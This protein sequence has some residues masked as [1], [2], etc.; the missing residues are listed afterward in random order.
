MFGTA[1]AS[2]PG[3]LF[4]LSTTSAAQ[5]GGLFGSTPAS[6]PAA[7]GLF[8]TAPA[9]GQTGGLFGSNS[10]TSK[11]GGG[12]FGS[13]ATTQP[14]T[15]GLFGSAQPQQQSGGL[16]GSTATSQPAPTGLFGASTTTSQPQQAGGLFGAT[17][18]AAPSLNSNPGGGL[19]SGL[20]SQN[21]TQNKP[22]NSLFGGLGGSTTQNQ[23]QQQQQQQQQP[24]S[25]LNQNQG[26]GLFGATLGGGLT[27][28]QSTN[29][30]QSQ[31][32]PGVRIDVSQLRGTTRFTDLHDDIQKQI[33]M[34]DDV[35]QS[36]IRLKYDCD[37]I[38]PAHA[39][40]LAQVPNDVEFCRRKRIGVENSQDSDAQAI[41]I[42][43][44]LIKVDAE[45]AKLSFKAI[46][47]LKLPPQYHNQ[48]VYAND[49]LGQGNGDED[50]QDIVGFFG[51]TADELAAT[52]NTYQKHIME[53]EQHLRSVEASSAQQINAL[54]AKRKG[55][56]T[57]Q[58]DPTN[59]LF[60]V[61]RD[62]EHGLLSVAGKIGASR[63]GVRT[64]QLG[65]FNS[66]H[67]GKT[68]GHKSGLY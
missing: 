50:A 68:N 35:I 40:Q 8:G 41:S 18:N 29:S 4:G 28:G 24:G 45:H 17:N 26:S 38:M 6:Q 56:T 59:E 63:E 53:I 57:A 30:P 12:L 2:K 46:D 25:M 15:G 14:Q 33:T 37:A 48:G 67:N 11:A 66:G 3:G 22:A 27:L 34:Y 54:V 19:F 36:Q 13:T 65:Q 16:F 51:S 62:F 47:N 5:T 1:G 43:G 58:E 23:T 7:G 64:L 39:N 32:V 21:A 9:Q 61:L 44:K 42:V 20:N 10:A 49:N 55:A 31:S 60:G 52:L